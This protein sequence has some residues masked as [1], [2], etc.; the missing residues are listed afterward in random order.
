M[1]KSPTGE[2]GRIDLAH[3]NVSQLQAK[4]ESVRRE[5]R[6]LTMMGLDPSQT[7][8]QATLIKELSGQRGP[9]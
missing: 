6:N 1:C 9:K 5:V 2:T 8:D 7:P 3:A 4:L